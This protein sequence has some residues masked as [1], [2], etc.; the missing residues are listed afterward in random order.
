MDLKG[1][2]KRKLL[3]GL[4]FVKDV[5]GFVRIPRHVGNVDVL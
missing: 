5:I 3:I 2:A 4:K 1:P